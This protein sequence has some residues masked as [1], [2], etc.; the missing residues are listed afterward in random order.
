MTASE[1][2]AVTWV[3]HASALIELD[4]VRFLT[5]PLLTKR[6]AHLRRRVGTPPA[7][8]AEV[9][10]VLISHLHLDHLHLPSLKLIARS[11]TVIAPRGAGQLLRRA[12]FVDVVELVVG[13]H[14]SVGGVVVTAVPAEHHEGRGPHSRAR[15]EPLGF[16]LS[17]EHTRVYFPGD[18]DL[19][20][21]MRDL[22]PI[23]VA[24]LPIWGWGPSLGPGHLDP[25]GAAAA[26][27]RIEPRL[28]VPIHWG[29]YAPENARRLPGGWFDRP[30]STFEL[31]LDE[32]D[33]RDRLHA[34]A[35]GETVTVLPS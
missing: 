32:H 35:P 11:T 1:A 14:T 19:T 25:S 8:T 21:A 17:G 20:E 15:A 13:G 27:A 33:R 28:V 31:A 16:V 30:L 18:T 4:G 5:D 34:L 2:T 22:G 10:A 12:G 6:V 26:T 29:T 7:D 23:D 24:L 3:G 9:D